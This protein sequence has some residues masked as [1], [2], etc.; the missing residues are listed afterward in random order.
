MH[1]ISGL[2]SFVFD[3]F[4]HS[5]RSVD[6]S[7]LLSSLL[8]CVLFSFFFSPVC[9]CACVCVCVFLSNRFSTTKMFTGAQPFPNWHVAVAWHFYFSRAQTK[10]S[11]CTHNVR[12]GVLLNSAQFDRLSCSFYLYNLF[13]SPSMLFVLAFY[14]SFLFHFLLVFWFLSC[15]L[16]WQSTACLLHVNAH[17]LSVE[18]HCA[19]QSTTLPC[20]PRCIWF[21]SVRSHRID[22]V[23]HIEWHKTCKYVVGKGE[24][25]GEHKPS[26]HRMK[27][28]R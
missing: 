6:A 27:N 17:F 7:L 9:E 22:G 28:E 13:L 15:V 19:Y 2:F 24:S 25:D 10:P 11:S 3:D 20:V 8:V 12:S 23:H 4:L 1:A 14:V 26:P 16:L 5:A 18:E 21:G